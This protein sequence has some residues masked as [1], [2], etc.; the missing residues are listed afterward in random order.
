MSRGPGRPPKNLDYNLEGV[1]ELPLSPAESF[2]PHDRKSVEWAVTHRPVNW[3]GVFV[4]ET[5]LNSDK[6]R[7]CKMY[8][9]DGDIHIYCSKVPGKFLKVWGPNISHGLVIDKPEEV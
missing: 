5:M 2:N 8:A 7:G 6:I 9:V 1:E 4:N 3:F